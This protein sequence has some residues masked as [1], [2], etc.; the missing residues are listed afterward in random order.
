MNGKCCRNG[1]NRLV[2]DFLYIDLEECERCQSSDETLDRAV[3]ELR[4]PLHQNDIV[5]ITTNKTKITSDEQAEKYGL[6]RSPTLRIND[7]DIEEIVNEDYE[8]KD[9]YCPS[10][11]DV[12]GPECDEITGGGN[13]CRVFEYEGDTYETIPK[14]MIKEAIR[15]K[16]G[17]EK[18][19]TSACCE[20]KTENSSCCETTDSCC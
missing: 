7:T 14:E 1:Q 16:V 8:V 2:I 10:C 18:K 19:I 5:T 4:E 6:I 15:K 20:P 11:G 17:I 3:R 13:E 12:T 9:N